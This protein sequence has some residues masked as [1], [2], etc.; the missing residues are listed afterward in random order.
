MRKNKWLHSDD[1]T[2][3]I[4]A[5]WVAHRGNEDML[6]RQ[7]HR[8][9]LSSCRRIWRLLP[10]PGSKKGVEAGENYLLGLATDIQLTHANVFAESAAFT[11][12]YGLHKEV[13]DRWVAE[14]EQ[15]PISELTGMLHPSGISPVPSAKEL[16]LRAAYFVD[17][18]MLYPRLRPL[19]AE[20][21]ESLFLSATLLREHFPDAEIGF[22]N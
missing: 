21:P 8:Y 22:R 5:L 3:M 6:V 17:F 18:A 4:A 2:A 12:D 19:E 9:Y 11:F 10:H 15:I 16:L 20:P 1:V 13:T 7:L 14:V